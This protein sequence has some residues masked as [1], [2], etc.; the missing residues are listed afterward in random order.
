MLQS[1]PTMESQSLV[2][3][4]AIAELA[5]LGFVTIITA[6]G[7]EPNSPDYP[8]RRLMLAVLEGALADAGRVA[9]QN[10]S[11]R[12][13]EIEQVAQ[14]LRWWASSRETDW[15]FSLQAICGVFG[16]DGHAV[17]RG[18]LEIL[19]GHR[20]F[21]RGR[22]LHAGAARGRTLRLRDRSRRAA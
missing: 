15:P 3:D 4:T 14:D 18:L 1:V 21:N 11:E 13:G 17:S 6:P 8:E 16:L 20:P 5:D 19:D 2:S 22:R 7:I 12:Q 10:P 9:K